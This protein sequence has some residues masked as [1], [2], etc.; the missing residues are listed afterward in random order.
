[1]KSENWLEV[2]VAVTPEITE[3][4]GNCLFE[5][6]SVGIV[7]QEGF[8]HAYFPAH[9]NSAGIKKQLSQYLDSLKKM[10]Y[11]VDS[12]AITLTDIAN[13]DWNSEWKKGFKPL[14]ISE[15]ILVKP[16]WC[17]T[18]ADAPAVV[19]AIDPEMAFGT[20]T[21]ATTSMCM[22]LMDSRTC[23]KTILDAGTGTGILAILAAMQG[24]NR[25]WA[26]DNDPVATATAKKNAVQNEIQQN[27]L[28]FTGTLSVVKNIRFDLVVANINRS[29]IIS[30]LP[31][32]Y[33]LL[34]QQG[35]FILSGI[36]DSEKNLVTAALTQNR[37]QITAITQKDEWLAFECTK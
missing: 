11:S 12:N 24:A 31:D 7:E 36:L 26:F 21:H 19:I 4:I 16:T 27:I 8:L 22:T 34:N 10:G 6:G 20:G 17:E 37:F 2:I 30:M 15:N 5:A 14:W 3:S 33:R 29:Q 1:M 35:L 9:S 13:Q 28:F 23:G 18:P 32:F 25:V